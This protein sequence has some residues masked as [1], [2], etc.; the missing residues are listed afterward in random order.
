[1]KRMMISALA[2]IAVAMAGLAPAPALSADRNQEALGVLLGAAAI[3]LLI[4]EISKDNDKKKVS[5]SG[6]TQTRRLDDW[7]TESHRDK[8]PGRYHP[9][10][11]PAACV[12][13]VGGRDVVSARCMEEF[14][15]RSHLPDGC[16]FKIRTRWGKRTVYDTRCL[17][18][19]GFRFD[20][21]ARHGHDSHRHKHDRDD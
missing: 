20:R 5:K 9:R 13:P 14:G 12:F 7:K 4:N 19:Y 1:M 16:G 11:I 6:S 15:V 17:R 21:H 2:A 8:R 18:N 3:G 10:A